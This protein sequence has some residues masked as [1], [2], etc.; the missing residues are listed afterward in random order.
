MPAVGDERE[1]A[2]ERAVR[3]LARRDH[4]T[5]S[6]RNKL[7]RAGVSEQAR[8]EAVDWLARA[9]YLDDAR[10]ARDRAASL[11][12]RGY[13]DEW[14]HA[15]LDRQGVAKEA[16]DAALASMEPEAKR[17]LREAERLGGGLQTAR[18]LLRRGFRE[19]S[20]EPLLEGPLRATPEA[21]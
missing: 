19:E 14:I 6:L 10:F 5:E 21:E 1:Q 7:E 13:G 3:F 17:A 20:L 15:D 12:A 2:R 9:G 8:D 16:A 18:T 11:A 4:S